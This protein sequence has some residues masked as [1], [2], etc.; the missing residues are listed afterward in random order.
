MAKRKSPIE[1]LQ[2]ELANL[3]DEVEELVER[4][5]SAESDLSDLASDE[6]EDE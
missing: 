3:R 1:K 6:G 2:T 5:E 4:I